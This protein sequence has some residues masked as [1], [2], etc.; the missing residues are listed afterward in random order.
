MQYSSGKNSDVQRAK[1]PEL[2]DAV[3]QAISHSPGSPLPI[4]LT[5]A[6]SEFPDRVQPAIVYL[7]HQQQRRA[8]QNPV[9][10]LY[11]AIV[12]GWNLPQPSD[13]ATPAGFRD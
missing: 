9:G 10:Y 8:I 1:F 5:T 7:R 12:E 2:F 6:V 11:R 4:A 13:A 3:A